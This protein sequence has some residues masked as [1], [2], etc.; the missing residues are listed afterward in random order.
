MGGSNPPFFEEAKTSSDMND[1][2]DRVHTMFIEHPYYSCM[3]VGAFML[4]MMIYVFLQYEHTNVTKNHKV[5]WELKQI[6]E[7][8]SEL[9][10]D[11]KERFIK[12]QTKARH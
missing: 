5:Q 8:E 9:C 11:M 6:Q 1:L 12:E 2:L 10:E 3:A 7:E 4:S